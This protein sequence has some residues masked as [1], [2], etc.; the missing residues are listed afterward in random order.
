MSDDEKVVDYL[1]WVTVDLHDTRR[2]LREV[3]DRDSEPIAIVGM[4]CRYPG[5]VRSPEDCGN[6]CVGAVMRS[7][8]SRRIAAGTWRGCMTPIAIDLG[9]SYM[10]EGGF[11]Y[12][13]GDFDSGFFGIGPRRGAR[14]G[15]PAADA[16][17]K[18]LGDFEDAGIDPHSLPGSQTGVFVGVGTSDYAAGL[19]SES[20]QGR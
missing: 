8:V 14:D 9:T 13:A 7:R 16:C 15:S 6:W 1:K 3:E 19:F 5:G 2:R 17:W 12:D 4:G 20:V 18:L 10:R 11:L